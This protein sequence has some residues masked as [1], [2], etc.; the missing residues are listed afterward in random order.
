VDSAD[1]HKRVASASNSLS[2]GKKKKNA[3]KQIEDERTKRLKN[4]MRSSRKLT[5]ARQINSKNTSTK[6][7]CLWLSR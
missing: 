5:F 1:E 2:P 3:G 7:D 4:V 6:Q